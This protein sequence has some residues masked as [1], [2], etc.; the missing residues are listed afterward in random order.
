M[1]PCTPGRYLY[2]SR[3]PAPARRP[4]LAGPTPQSRRRWTEFAL[5]GVMMSGP[6]YRNALRCDCAARLLGAA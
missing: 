1:A 4:G 2:L 3:G 6:D 5:V